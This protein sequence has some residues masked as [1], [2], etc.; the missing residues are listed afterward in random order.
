MC[1]GC[2]S[3]GL[4]LRDVDNEGR[5]IIRFTARSGFLDQESLEFPLYE[6]RLTVDAFDK[7]GQSPLP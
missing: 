3:K 1:C 4:N 2:S 6:T 5:T 7:A